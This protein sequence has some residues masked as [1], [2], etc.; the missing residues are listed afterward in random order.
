[1]PQFIKHPA[2]K[3]EL[4]EVVSDTYP[5][6]FSQ[7][8]AFRLKNVFLLNV[9]YIFIDLPTEYTQKCI[10]N[11]VAIFRKIEAKMKMLVA[12]VNKIS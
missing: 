4:S 6:T 10:L 5:D 1:M 12:I 11:K 3:W 2:E 9:F 8:P 7:N